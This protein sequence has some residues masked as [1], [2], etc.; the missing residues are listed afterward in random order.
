MV[1][2][3]PET[4]MGVSWSWKRTVERKMVMTSLKMPATESVTT[5]VRWMSLR[6][7]ESDSSARATPR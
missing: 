5:D 2:H 7:R 3:R 1:T 4:L 6:A